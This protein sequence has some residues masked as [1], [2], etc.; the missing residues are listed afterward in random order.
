MSSATFCA[1]FAAFALAALAWRMWLGVRQMRHVASH[2]D[3]VPADF[4]AYIPIE[5]H[6]KAADYTLDK[7][8]VALAEALVID[9]ALLFFLTLGGG[10][11]M[12]DAW[13]HAHLGDGYLRDLGTVFGVMIVSGVLALPF[14]AWRTFVI[15][16][17]HGFNR[18]TPAVFVLD[19]LKGALLAVALGAPLLLGV[20]WLVDA[21]GPYWWLYAWIGW[22]AF[23]LALVMVY[24]R[25]IAPLFN[26]FTPLEEGDLRRR[27]EALIERCGF[28]AKGL[29]VMDGSRR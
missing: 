20:F 24:P 3:A 11:A 15:E 10:V 17:R 14:D 2:R 22:I 28:H 7:Q 5:A 27:I 13:S 19:L 8:R 25:W 9:G 23:T 16:S 18:T 12:I 6:R 29:F 21:A 1:V 26:R 4:A